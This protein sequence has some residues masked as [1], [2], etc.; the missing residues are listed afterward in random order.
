MLLQR[1]VVMFYSLWALLQRIKHKKWILLVIASFYMGIRSTLKEPFVGKLREVV[2]NQMATETKDDGVHMLPTPIVAPWTNTSFECV[3]WKRIHSC[4]QEKTNDNAEIMAEPEKDL[5]G[6]SEEIG[7]QMAGYCIVRNRTSGDLYKLMIT[8]CDSLPTGYYTCDMARDFSEFGYHSKRYKHTPVAPTLA[9][10][11]AATSKREPTNGVL[12]I[13]Y[14]RILPSAYATIRMLRVQGCELPVELWY[15]PDEM[16]IDNPIVYKLLLD[17]NVRVRPILDSRAM[18]FHVKPY[19]V[20][21]SSFDNILLLDADN[22]PAKDPTYLFEEPE[23]L[24]TGAIF[25]PDYWQPSNSLFQLSNTSLLWQLTGVNYVDMF[26]QESGQVL[27]DRL[28]SKRALDKLMYYSTHQPRLLENLHLLWGDKDLFRLAWLSSSQPFHFITYPPAVGGLNLQE[29]K[30]VFCGLAMIQ[31]DV[32]GNLVFFHRNSIKLDGKPGQPRLMSHIQEYSLE[33]NPRNYRIFQ[34]VNA[35]NKECCYYI[36]TDTLPDGR[37]ATQLTP[38]DS[39]IYASLEDMAIQFSVEARQLLIDDAIA[40]NLG[41]WSMRVQYITAVF[42]LVY[43]LGIIT[44]VWFKGRPA[45]ERLPSRWQPM[46][47]KES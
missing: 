35:Y 33:G 22:L 31:H 15:R 11:L 4:R 43:V 39:T 6:C 30:G 26:E 45:R 46:D 24:R 27:I 28:R 29:E 44:F 1:L 12:M 32:Q 14:D 21:Y 23:F 7:T 10:P 47:S 25:W 13:I 19:A 20:Y 8:S 2:I 16:S 37:P 5:L 40:N 3:G 36:G 18:G 17:Y 42:L 9:L 41:F 34:A 38:I